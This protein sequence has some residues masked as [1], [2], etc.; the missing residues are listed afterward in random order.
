MAGAVA[1]ERHRRPVP[2]RRTVR[3]LRLCAGLA[4]CAGAHRRAGGHG[5]AALPAAADAA[6]AA[7]AR[8][9]PAAGTRL[10]ARTPAHHRTRRHA[11]GGPGRCLGGGPVAR[12]Y[13]A[14][15][16]SGPQ[17]ARGLALARTGGKRSPC[18][19]LCGAAAAGGQ[20]RRGRSGLEPAAGQCLAARLRERWRDGAA[21][22]LDQSARLYRRSPD[23]S[24]AHDPRR[25]DHLPRPPAP[26]WCYACMAPAGSP[27]VHVVGGSGDEAPLPRP[28]PRISR[29]TMPST[30]AWS[31]PYRRTGVRSA[32]GA[33]M[34]CRTPRR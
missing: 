15:A 12:P 18:A 11:G 1:G 7:M 16:R 5:L 3:S 8:W 30:T 26:S 21:R 34:W 9:C 20:L 27:R 19:A 10:H 28:G 17:A 31:S 25:K 29:P 13:Q 33:S 24:Q 4:A 6:A 22:R 23:L 14:P 2:G 32:A